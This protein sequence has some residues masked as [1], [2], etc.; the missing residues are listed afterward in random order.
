L[1]KFKNEEDME[2]KNGK[3]EVKSGAGVGGDS[4]FQLRPTK[5]AAVQETE[6]ARPALSAIRNSRVISNRVWQHWP[7]SI[8]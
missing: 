7:Q 8:W 5:A 3:K 2:K 4:H 6:K 1:S